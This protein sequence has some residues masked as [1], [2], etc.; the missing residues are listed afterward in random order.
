LT[1]N[2][3][4][5]WTQW[6]DLDLTIYESGNDFRSFT[7]TERGARLRASLRNDD[8]R[9]VYVRASRKAAFRQETD[10]QEVAYRDKRRPVE[11]IILR[12]A[13]SIWSR[14]DCQLYRINW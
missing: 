7:S 10:P 14:D 1:G 8:I 5:N 6:H 12:H 2:V 3:V 4:D 9:F 13:R 11:T